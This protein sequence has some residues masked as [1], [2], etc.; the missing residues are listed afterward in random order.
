METNCLIRILICCF[1]AALWPS[2]G[3]PTHTRWPQGCEWSQWEQC[4]GVIHQV[5]VNG[6]NFTTCPIL[7][8]SEKKIQV[9]SLRPNK[10]LTGNST[11]GKKKRGGKYALVCLKQTQSTMLKTTKHPKTQTRGK[12]ASFIVFSGVKS[13]YFGVWMVT[14]A[15][16]VPSEPY[17]SVSIPPPQHRL[18]PLQKDSWMRA[19]WSLARGMEPGAKSHTLIYTHY[20]SLSS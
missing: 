14:V 17:L 5:F 15:G 10:P 16:S 19:F 9:T 6:R 2:S 13:L 1:H 12:V 4:R 18:L 20:V 11:H 7:L 3:H 8:K